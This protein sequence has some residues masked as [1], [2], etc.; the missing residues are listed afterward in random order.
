MQSQ[1]KPWLKL[2]LLG[3]TVSRSHMH[4]LVVG[5]PII[6]WHVDVNVNVMI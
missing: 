2:A 3:S 6:I 5:N 4:Q 1:A